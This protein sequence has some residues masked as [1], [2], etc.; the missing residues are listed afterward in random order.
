MFENL[1]SKEKREVESL[2]ELMNV[3]CCNSG[4]LILLGE[5]VAVY[6]DNG[7]GKEFLGYGKFMWDEFDRM[8]ILAGDPEVNQKLG[9]DFHGVE[10]NAFRCIVAKVSPSERIK[11]LNKNG[12]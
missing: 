9:I 1:T 12:K 11:L 6:N 4:D 10:E 7:I 5:T 3:K 8:F 2:S